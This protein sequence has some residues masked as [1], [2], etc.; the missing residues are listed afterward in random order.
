M[1]TLLVPGTYVQYGGERHAVEAVG[2]TGGERY[3]WLISEHGVV[4]M[5]PACVVEGA[6]RGLPV[7]GAREEGK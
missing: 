2:I 6:G 5:L 3:Y 4:S 1:S 7:P